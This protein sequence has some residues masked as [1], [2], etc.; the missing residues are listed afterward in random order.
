MIVAILLVIAR[1]L[2]IAAPSFRERAIAEEVE[3]KAVKQQI[4]ALAPFVREHPGRFSAEDLAQFSE[5]LERFG[6]KPVMG[7]DA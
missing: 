2:S 5:H 3:E 4:L 6:E 1:I 7:N